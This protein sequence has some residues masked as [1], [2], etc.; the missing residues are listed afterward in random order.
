MPRIAKFSLSIPKGNQELFSNQLL[1]QFSQNLTFSSCI[2]S[3]HFVFRHLG[4]SA[5]QYNRG[6]L[7]RR[8]EAACK[9]VV[10]VSINLSYVLGI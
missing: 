10:R 4:V 5:D 7:Q 8:I 3:R 2:D 1:G 6:A 9:D